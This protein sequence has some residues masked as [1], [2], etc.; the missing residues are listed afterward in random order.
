[1]NLRIKLLNKLFLEDNE[2]FDEFS[3]ELYN[4]LSKGELYESFWI[5]LGKEQDEK[6]ERLYWD[7]YEDWKNHMKNPHAFSSIMKWIML[8]VLMFNMEKK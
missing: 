3:G 6:R 8:S 2:N 1:M 5:R 7:S 4:S